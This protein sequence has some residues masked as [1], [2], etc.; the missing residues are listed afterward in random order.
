MPGKRINR[1]TRLAVALVCALSAVSVAASPLFES[2]AVLNVKISAPLTTLVRE[3]SNTD[4]YDGELRLIAASSEPQL[5]SLKLR[6]RGNFRRQRDTC[7]FPPVRLNFD[8]DEVPGTVFEGQNILKLVT[9]CRPGNNAFE[10]LV[11]REY[12]AYKILEL[13]TPAAFRARLLRVTW[14]D[15]ER[16][17]RTEERY[18]FVIEH[19]NELAERLDRE[20]HEEGTTHDALDSQQAA[21]VA[22]FQYLIGNTDFSLVAGR[23]DDTCCHN[24]ILLG[25]PTQP[26]IAVPYDFD[27]SGL[28]NAPYASPNPRFK[29]RSVTQRLY[30]GNCALNHEVAGVAELFLARRDDVRALVEQQ[31]GL[32]R[33]SRRRMLSFLEKF[34]AD[35]GSA[36]RL[37]SRLIRNCS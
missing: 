23:P 27:F 26:L 17:G 3:R 16:N 18:G 24:G 10:Q 35:I 37:E 19:K 6:A 28:V 5:L 9:H 15:T 32:S 21:I 31:V 1:I 34:Y 14:A 4:Y 7:R 8:K 33:Q 2:N 12:L 20:A 29:L 22:L 25:K 30:R 36:E 13:H 11:V